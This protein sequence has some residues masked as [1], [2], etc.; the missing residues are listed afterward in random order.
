V[1]VDAQDSRRDLMFVAAD[2]QHERQLSWSDRT[3]LAALSD[4]GRQVVFTAYSS[5]LLSTFLE[6]TDGSSPLKLG[7]GHALALSH[8]GKWVLARPDDYR[9]A[10]SLLPVGPGAARTLPL[11]GL[12]VTA[13]RWLRDGKHVVFTGRPTS[14][15]QSRLYAVA[16]EAGAPTRISETAINPFYIEVSSDDQL[17]AA[18]DL[19]ERVTLFPIGGGPAVQLPELGKEVVPA[20]WAASGQLWVRTRDVPSHMRSYDIRSRRA[21]EERTISPSDPTGVSRIPTVRIT[22]DGRSVAFDYERTLSYL[23]LL[24]GLSPARR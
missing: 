9:E 24:E 2:G 10:L 5:G 3:D 18:R 23:Y 1:L 16:L 12:D 13:A 22:P 15:K 7:A 4:D 14:D 17:V 19:D 6:P 20:G 11:P 21:L 8:D